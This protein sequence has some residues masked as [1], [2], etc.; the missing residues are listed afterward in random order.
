MYLW[1]FGSTREYP[2]LSPLLFLAFPKLL[3]SHIAIR[4]GILASLK[5]LLSNVNIVFFSLQPC[6]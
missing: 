1:S 3:L 6:F 2:T 4:M 5:M